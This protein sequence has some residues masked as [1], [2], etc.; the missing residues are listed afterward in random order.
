MTSARWQSRK[1]QT[2]LPHKHTDSA[3]SLGQIPFMGN[4]E[5]NLKAPRPQANA[6]SDSLKPVGSFGTP[7]C[8]NPC[9]WHSTIQPGRSPCPSFPQGRERV[10]SHIQHSNFS[11]GAPQGAGCRLASCGDLKGLAQS[12][13]LGE[14]GDGGLAS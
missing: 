10:G 4:P 14:S 3:T 5:T 13:R 6:R 2:P 9:P 11:E 1:P 8:Q 12:S 7:C